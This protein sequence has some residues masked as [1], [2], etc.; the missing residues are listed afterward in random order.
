MQK[1]QRITLRDGSQMA[2]IMF[3]S[4]HNDFDLAIRE[5]TLLFQEDS[6]LSALQTIW[7]PP[8]AAAMV[9]VSSLIS[10]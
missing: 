1:C 5:A 4:F 10:L 9:V 8:A 6:K 7:I 2:E 3:D